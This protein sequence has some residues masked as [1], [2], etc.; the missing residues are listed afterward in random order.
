MRHA[1]LG[2]NDCA[3]S[4]LTGIPRSTIRDWRVK[5]P[6]NGHGQCPICDGAELPCRDYAYLLGLYLGDGCLTAAPRGVFKLRITLD[7][8]Y[9]GII[10][11]AGEAIR[12][13]RPRGA[14]T[15]GQVRRPGCIEVNAHWKHWPCLFPQHGPGVKHRRKIELAPWQM[16]IL[17]EWPGGL[18][19]GLI[20]SDGY[21]GANKVKVRG[22]SYAYSRY[23]FCNYSA[24]I[25]GIFCWACDFYGVGWRRMNERTIAVSRRADVAKLDEI[26][27]PK[28]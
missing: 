26:I 19:R 5:G 4:R 6:T 22:K 7:Q 1:A 14:M 24:D 11:E 27:G 21:R 15:I 8:K 18:L 28:R 23:Q 13:M 2:M 25:R 17:E 3:I 9:P 10:R 20:H 12:A 16:G